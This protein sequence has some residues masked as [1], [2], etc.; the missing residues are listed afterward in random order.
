MRT[1]TT[2]D[3]YV[4]RARFTASDRPVPPDFDLAAVVGRRRA[5][6]AARDMIPAWSARLA[7]RV[8]PFVARLAGV[9]RSARLALALLLATG[10]GYRRDEAVEGR[11]S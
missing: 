4:S 10:A 6:R 7:R 11:Q 8:A 5:R 1:T 3:R 9:R 2:A